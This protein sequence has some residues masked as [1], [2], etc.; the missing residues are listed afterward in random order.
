MIPTNKSINS[1]HFPYQAC[2]VPNL[3]EDPQHQVRDISNYIV[4]PLD[5]L[6]AVMSFICN[7]LVFIT[8]TRTKSLRHPSLMMLCSL[9]ITDMIWALFT[10]INNCLVLIHPHMCPE[11]GYE[12]QC[13]GILCYLATLSNLAMISRD[14]YLAMSRPAWYRSHVSRS[15]ARAVR[16]TLLSWVSSMFTALTVYTI[17]KMGISYFKLVIFIIIFL[18]YVVCILVIVFNYVRILMA[19]RQHSKSMRIHVGK[20]RCAASEREKKLTRIISVILLCFLFSFLPALISPVILVALSISPKPFRPFNFLLFTLN[21]FLNPL[22]NYGRNKDIRRAM[23]NMLGFRRRRISNQQLS[24]V[25]YYYRNGQE[26]DNNI[27]V[28]SRERHLQELHIARN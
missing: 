4:V 3:P 1:S 5:T 20:M 21:G 9:S 18:F 19:N 15:R 27:A 28:Q 2:L 6:L 10:I 8:I 11:Y 22:L 14:R 12:K 13:I 23:L 7:T 17:L 16:A 24:A 26:A 25:R